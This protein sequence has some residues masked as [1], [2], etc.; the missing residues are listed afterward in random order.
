M[1][2]PGQQSEAHWNEEA[3]ALLAGLIMFAVAH[4]DQDRKTLA[5]V[6]E[7]LTLPPEKFRTLLELMQDRMLPGD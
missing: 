3:K 5:T 4:E 2:P 7:Y 6:R 1:D